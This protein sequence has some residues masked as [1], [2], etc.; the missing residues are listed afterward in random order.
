M[1]EVLY[2]VYY[3]DNANNAG[4]YSIESIEIEFM[5]DSNLDLDPKFCQV[6]NKESFLITQKFGIEFVV[7]RENAGVLIKTLEEMAETGEVTRSGNPGYQI[8]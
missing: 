7:A 6:D 4:L 8:N 2:R 3:G 1:S 5:L